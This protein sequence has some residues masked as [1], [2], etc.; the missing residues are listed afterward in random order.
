MTRRKDFIPQKNGRPTHVPTEQNK[1]IVV[2]AKATRINMEDI[3]AMIGISTETLNKHYAHELAVGKSM[4][5]LKCADALMRGIVKGDAALIKYY[6]NNQMKWSDKAA[7]DITSGNQPITS[8]RHVFTLD[9]GDKKIN[10]DEQQESGDPIEA[11]EC[12]NKD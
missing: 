1:R 12:G 5:D 10:A 2:I 6:M 4:C 11:V 3:A 8:V 7:V 9:M